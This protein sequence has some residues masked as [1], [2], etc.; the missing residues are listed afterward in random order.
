MSELTA[1][2]AVLGGLAFVLVNIAIWSPRKLRVKM[3]ALATAAIFPPTAYKIGR[4][5][6]R[7]RV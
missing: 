5:P 4:A 1:V 2:F 6:C 7:E 3:G